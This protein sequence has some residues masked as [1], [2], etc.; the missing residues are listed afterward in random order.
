[1]SFGDAFD[2]HDLRDAYQRLLN[3]YLS[4]QVER[5]ELAPKCPFPRTSWPD[6]PNT[7]AAHTMRHW[8]DRLTVGDAEFLHSVGID[9]LG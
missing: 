9:P 2:A 1:M 5:M 6:L 7:E 3:Q 8:L 4:R